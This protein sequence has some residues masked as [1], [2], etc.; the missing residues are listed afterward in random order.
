MSFLIFEI[1]NLTQLH[2]LYADDTR[3]TDEGLKKLTQLRELDV[4]NTSITDNSIKHLT[5][6]NYLVA[7]YTKITDD[8]NINHH[9]GLCRSYM[10]NVT[11]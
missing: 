10:K 5:H 2:A 1:K 6:L 4:G 11:M 7:S 3:I 8:G 9:G